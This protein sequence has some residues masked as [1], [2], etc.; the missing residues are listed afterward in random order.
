MDGTSTTGVHRGRPPRGW[1]TGYARHAG[2]DKGYVSR[3]VNHRGMPTGSYEEADRWRAANASEGVGH[4]SKGGDKAPVVMTRELACEVADALVA[5]LPPVDDAVAVDGDGIE[6]AAVRAR[7]A[8]RQA[9][10]ALRDAA[11]KARLALN[12]SGMEAADISR[13]RM[14]AAAALPGLL[15]TW[16]QAARVRLDIE[17]RATDLLREQ[18][19]LAPVGEV[20]GVLLEV[21]QPIVDGLKHLPHI[22]GPRANPDNPGAAEAVLREECDALLRRVQRVASSKGFPSQSTKG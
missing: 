3:L 21:V 7:D 16:T 13:V 12:T 20:W 14:D 18:G 19:D 15:R 6:A 4:K 2:C 17:K 22:V 10:L 5:E 11:A 1:I 8:E 9:H